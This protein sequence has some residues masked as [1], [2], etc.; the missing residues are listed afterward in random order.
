MS[1]VLWIIKN[2]IISA[3]LFFVKSIMPSS[4]HQSDSWSIRIS[5]L[6]SFHKWVIF[7]SRLIINIMECN[8]YYLLYGEEY[9]IS[10]NIICFRGL[11]EIEMYL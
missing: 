11:I 5:M 9:D 2:Y 7:T 3:V 6:L 4:V 8:A 10:L 1:Q